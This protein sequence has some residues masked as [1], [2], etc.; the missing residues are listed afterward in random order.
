MPIRVDDFADS[1]K[2]YADQLNSQIEQ[3]SRSLTHLDKLL[4]AGLVDR[5]VLS[6]FREAVDR[7][8]TTGYVVQ[9]AIDGSGPG[10]QITDA[11]L[12]ERIGAATRTLKYLTA[13]LKSSRPAGPIAGA[14]EL[15]AAL[16]QLLEILQEK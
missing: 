3:V 10:A 6:S 15:Q 14:D 11:V 12:R 8:R 9:Q 4:V 5:R 1:G 16:R 7:V 13:D 2:A